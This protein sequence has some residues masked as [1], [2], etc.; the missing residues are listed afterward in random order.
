M[1]GWIPPIRDYDTTGK[2]PHFPLA[3]LNHVADDPLCRQRVPGN[4]AACAELA[5]IGNVECLVSKTQ[6]PQGQA[7]IQG[8]GI[9]SSW[10]CNDGP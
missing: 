10:V 8:C 1:K 9:V 6:H 5:I 3:I 7:L 2:M 4:T